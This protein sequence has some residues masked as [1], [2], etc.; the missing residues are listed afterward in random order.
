MTI[1]K[2]WNGRSGVFLFYF[3]TVDIKKKKPY[4]IRFLIIFT[5]GEG[6]I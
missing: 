3:S 4:F 1:E 5:N 6:G 2:P